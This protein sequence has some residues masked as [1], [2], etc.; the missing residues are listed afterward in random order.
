MTMLTSTVEV[1]RQRCAWHAASRGTGRNSVVLSP[2]Q[3]CRVTCRRESSPSPIG[4][5]RMWKACSWQS[6][7]GCS[8]WPTVIALTPQGHR[9][10]GAGQHYCSQCRGAWRWGGLEWGREGRGR[11]WGG[12]GAGGG[13]GGGTGMVGVAQA[14]PAQTAPLTAPTRLPTPLAQQQAP[15]AV[16][17]EVISDANPLC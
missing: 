17:K 15:T 9:G 4:Q 16:T 5:S 3:S 7:G 8:T 6:A 13:R 12:R 11:A 2:T 1:C 10:T 14:A